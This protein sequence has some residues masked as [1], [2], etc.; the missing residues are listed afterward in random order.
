MYAGQIVHNITSMY[1]FW[2]Y[3]RSQ[4]IHKKLAHKI[5]NLASLPEIVVL[6]ELILFT[7]CITPCYADIVYMVFKANNVF[8]AI[9]SKLLFPGYIHSIKRCA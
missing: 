3:M 5:G 8:Y 6:T 2:Y 4:N 7:P 1:N 9:P